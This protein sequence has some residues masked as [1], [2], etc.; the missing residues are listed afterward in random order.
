MAQAGDPVAQAGDPGSFRDRSGRVFVRDGVLY[1][2]VNRSF[3]RHYDALMASGLYEALTERGL[4]VHHQED[5][6][7]EPLSPDAYRVLRPERV[8]FV[9]YPYEWCFGQLRDAALA[10]LEIGKLALEHGMS[11]RDASAYNIQFREGGAV[12]IDTLSFEILREGEPWVAYRQFCQHFLAPLALMRYRDLRLG[13]L[14][15]LHVDGVP[16]DLALSLLPWRTRLRL[17]LLVHLHLHGRSLRRNAGT[18]P[19]REGRFSLRAFQGLVDSLRGAVEKL[20]LP[21]TSSAWTGYYSEG[22]SYA[23]EALAH[24]EQLVEEFVTEADPSSLWDLGANTGRFSRIAAARGIPTV[25]FDVDPASVQVAYRTVVNDGETN[26]LP[27]V[28][29]L[30]NPSP[31]IGWAGR[32]RADL[33]S[34][35][36]TDVVMALALVHHLAIG[37]NVPLDRIVS[38]FA[39]LA[40]RLIVEFVPKSDPK[41]RLL[42]GAREDI[43]D[44][45]TQRGFETAFETRYEIERREPIKASERSLY[46]MRR[47]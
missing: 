14:F 38:F 35:G 42:L 10:T 9:S 45:Y 44:D 29:D 22:D 26:L 17:G 39:E 15:R 40:P 1:R 43:F 4:L 2:Q 20:H 27:L 30:T 47:R 12:L 24:K 41:V 28:L 25:A 46:L 18:V 7:A 3:Q 5:D 31:G 11:L 21:K 8:S 13:Q 33:V 32:E 16:L 36:P 19:R 6:A 37:N 34:R 23:P